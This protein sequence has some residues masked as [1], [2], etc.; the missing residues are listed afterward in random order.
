MDISL[1]G[2][3]KPTT[4]AALF[5][6]PFPVTIKGWKCHACGKE[7]SEN[8]EPPASSTPEEQAH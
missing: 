3:D 8:L 7:W 5:I 4:Y 6:M 2:L 1:D